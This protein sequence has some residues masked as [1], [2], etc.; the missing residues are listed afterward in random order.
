MLLIFQHAQW[1]HRG[2]CS[3]LNNL[4]ELRVEESHPLFFPS[5]HICD[6]MKAMRKFLVGLPNSF[7]TFC[8]QCVISGPSRYHSIDFSNSLRRR[9]DW[10][11][12]GYSPNGFRGLRPVL[13]FC[14]FEFREPNESKSNKAS[15]G[16]VTA[17][18]QSP[19]KE[20]GESRGFGLKRTL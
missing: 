5:C 13:Y 15:S 12:I 6:L 8:R 16:N 2:L 20:R 4:S 11:L 18:F 9:A 14:M 10:I 17:S 19:T 3:R 1:H 7:K